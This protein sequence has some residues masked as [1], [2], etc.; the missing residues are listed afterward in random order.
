VGSASGGGLLC[1]GSGVLLGAVVDH[2]RFVAEQAERLLARLGAFRAIAAPD[3]AKICGPGGLLG[4]HAPRTSA[5]ART[6]AFT[7]RRAFCV[8]LCLRWP[9]ACLGGR[10]PVRAECGSDGQCWR[11]REGGQC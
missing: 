10:L 4:A 6:H 11:G 8:L 7:R 9:S 5:H 3:V 2:E 1:Y